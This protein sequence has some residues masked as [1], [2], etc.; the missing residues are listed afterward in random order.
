MELKLEF[1]ARRPA[2][3]VL[4]RRPMLFISQLEPWEDGVFAS[5]PPR[6]TKDSFVTVPTQVCRPLR[7]NRGSI[8][9]HAGS[10]IFEFATNDESDLNKGR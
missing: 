6:M 5:A 8:P 10:K 1:D 9:R 4:T 7:F 2:L 3:T